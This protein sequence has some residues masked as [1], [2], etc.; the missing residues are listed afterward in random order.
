MI[1]RIDETIEM[2]DLPT[3]LQE[4][5]EQNPSLARRAEKHYLELTEQCNIANVVVNEKGFKPCGEGDNICNCKDASECGYN[6][7]VGL[8]CECGNKISEKESFYGQCLM[9]NKDIE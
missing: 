6:S 3:W 2:K 5:W 8:V 7:E 4:L 1:H 9:C